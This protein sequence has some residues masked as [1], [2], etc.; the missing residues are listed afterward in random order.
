[1]ARPIGI[2]GEGTTGDA[3]RVQ[4]VPVVSPQN[5]RD[6]HDKEPDSRDPCGSSAKR[7]RHRA[8]AG[9]VSAGNGPRRA[10][11]SPLRPD[12]RDVSPV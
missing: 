9:P 7:C 4:P 12:S 6:R 3:L 11:R 2:P 8:A 1:M 10:R 5:W